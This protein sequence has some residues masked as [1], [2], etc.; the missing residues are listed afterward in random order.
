MRGMQTAQT[1]PKTRRGSGQQAARGQEAAERPV[2]QA[3]GRW[4]ARG[5]LL[6]P[7]EHSRD[8]SPRRRLVQPSGW[9]GTRLA[10]L[11]QRWLSATTQLVIISQRVKL[12]KVPRVQK[13]P[14]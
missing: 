12:W 1:S 4:A 2:T 8:L 3:A 5:P 11:A 7:E 6:V 13:S 9:P 14:A 10:G